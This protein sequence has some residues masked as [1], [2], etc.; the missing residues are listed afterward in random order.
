MIIESK[1]GSVQLSDILE[2]Y[3][4]DKQ[5]R[6][7]VLDRAT[8]SLYFARWSHYDDSFGD[9]CQTH[10]RGQFD[11]VR[12]EKRRITSEFRQNPVTIKYDAYNEEDEEAAEI[13]TG[14]YRNNILRSDCKDCFNMAQEDQLDCGMGAWRIVTEDEDDNPLNTNKVIRRMPIPEAVRRV[15]FD[16]NSLRLDK[17]DARRCSVINTYTEKGYKQFLKENDIDLDTVAFTSFDDPY[18]SY[19]QYH[20]PL[21][22][23]DRK[24]LNLLEQ[25]RITSEPETVLIYINPQSGEPVGFYKSE[26]SDVMDD[27]VEAGFG[28]PVNTKKVMRDVCTKYITNGVEIL[29]ETRVPGG[30]IPIIPIYGERN[31]IDGVENVE[32]LY[33][34]TKDAQRLID[35]QM[36]YLAELV[37]YSPVPKPEFDPREI[38]GL[39]GYHE[40]AN[41]SNLAYVLRNK[42]FTENGETINFPNPTYTQPPQ[43]PPSVAQLLELSTAFI[44]Q[45]TNPGLTEDSFNTNASGEALKQLA[46][47]IDILSYVF[48]DN[49][50]EGMRRDGEVSAAM[51]AEIMDTP[52]QV[53]MQNQDGTTQTAMVNESVFDAE[54]GQ[55]VTLRRVHQNKFYVS[56]DVGPSYQTQK[57][58]TVA[59]LKDLLNNL[60]SDPQDQQIKQIVLMGLL[61]NIEGQGLEPINRYARFNLLSQGLPGF[62]PETEEEEQFVEQLRQAQ[63]QQDQQQGPE[64]QWIQSEIMKNMTEMQNNAADSA[65]K[66]ADTQLTRAKTVETYAGID[67]NERQQYLD[68]LA[69]LLNMSQNRTVN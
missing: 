12:K 33:Q 46:K 48:I 56:Y 55:M 64:Q 24:R 5:Y 68:V 69:N 35:M 21:D 16:A 3:H 29:K 34:L 22:F 43:V 4:T 14:M 32:G 38:E 26:I 66:Q 61:S 51:T 65:K 40:D 53:T 42:V 57:E 44:Q 11:L 62:E 7:E 39:E 15:F 8:E 10:Y 60:G 20:Y 28:D 30:M 23:F 37:A 58:A 59:T 63:A 25:F 49:Y 13:M 67:A 36:N 45:N 54:T 6:W 52:R 41:D 50:A 2:D 47:Q 18:H 1:D 31:F 9:F 27:L 19:Y 17:S